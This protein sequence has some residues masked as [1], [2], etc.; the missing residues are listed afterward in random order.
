MGRAMFVPLLCLALI[1]CPKPPKN[2]PDAH[3]PFATAP[4]WQNWSEN[5]VHNAPTDG[6]NYYFSPT[7][8]AQLAELVR[9]APKD[10]SVSLRVSGGR[11]SQ[12]PLVADDNRSAPP[13]RATSWLIDL[14]CYADLG[15]AGQSRIVLDPAGA[16]V[17]VNTGVREDELDAFLTA[18]DLM[19]PTVTA[20]G[21][22]SLGGMTAVDVHGAAVAAPIFAETAVAFE[23]MG[24]DGEVSR[25]DTST[26]AVDGV[27]PIQHA[28]VSL[29]ALGV[30][31]SVTLSVKPRPWANTLQGGKESFKLETE[32][33]FIAKYKE[34]LASHDRLESF[35]DPYDR[36]FLVLWWDEVDDPQP[37][38]PNVPPS[39]ATACT[40]AEKGLFGA[41]YEGK[42]IE[43]I[44]ESS[45]E[46]DQYGKSKLT[47]GALIDLALEVIRAQ[48]E[49]ADKRS[50]DLWLNEAARVI[51]MSYF[52]ELPEVDDEGLAR[53]WSGLDAVNY[54]ME[55]DDSFLLA[56]PL[57]FRFIRGGNSSM[58]GTYTETPGSL[59]V[60]LDL[61]GFV[62]AEPASAY[63][64]ALLSFFADVERHW[65]DLGGRPH[66]GK[67]YGF[68][69][70]GT[71]QGTFTEPFNQ[72]FIDA[73]SARRGARQQ[74]FEAYRLSRDPTGLFCNAFLDGVLGCK[75]E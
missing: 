31:T 3:V 32:A 58:A 34:L 33:E 39:F 18:H 23:I 5:L 57:E 51:F 22:F 75:M 56:G 52:L 62:K 19:L 45:A 40:Y 72:A 25:I 60:N 48:V 59:F 27:P 42:L 16:T 49:E 4:V 63:P 12:P 53:V 68:Y 70:P 6:E 1:G 36:E 46:S 30:V 14:S 43:P 38:R 28:R 74:A 61:I 7:S 15:A 8:R 11:H 29:G 50:S 2:D 17:T 66:S 67:M 13:A 71:R 10:G 69:E 37:Q 20:G 47:A 73:L 44:A 54:R 65:V 24:P 35:Y 9:G 64:D 41:P 55:Q 26:P 21:F